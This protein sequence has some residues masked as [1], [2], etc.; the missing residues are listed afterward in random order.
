DF[1]KAKVLTVRFFA[2]HILPFAD[3]YR[4]AVINGASSVLAMEEA[5]F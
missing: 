1:L 3:G 2:D 5:Y 4:E